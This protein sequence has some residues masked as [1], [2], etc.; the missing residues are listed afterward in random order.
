[1]RIGN[2]LTKGIL[3][4]DGLAGNLAP[5]TISPLRDIATGRYFTLT[6]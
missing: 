6:K 1:L 2:A 4:S 3:W 5:I